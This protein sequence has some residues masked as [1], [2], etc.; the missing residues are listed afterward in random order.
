MVVVVEWEM[1][2]KSISIRAVSKPKNIII[3]M[4]GKIY[5]AS[6]CDVCAGGVLG[7]S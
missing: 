4:I 6:R 7:V 5:F 2:T 3:I 1:S